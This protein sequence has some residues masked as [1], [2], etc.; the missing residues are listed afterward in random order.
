LTWKSKAK[1][2]CSLYLTESEVFSIQGN[3]TILLS[4]LKNGNAIIDS[5]ARKPI[6]TVK[7][8]INGSEQTHYFYINQIGFE[9]R[10]L[11][12][13]LSPTDIIDAWELLGSENSELND[14]LIN[15]L[16]TLTD[17]QQ[18][19]S[20]KL[21][22]DN[23]VNKSLLNE[24]ARHFYGL[25]K[26][27]EFLFD[28]N[29]YK[30]NNSLQAAHSNN[31]RYYLTCDNV[32]TLYSYI[33]Y[34]GKQYTNDTIMSTYYWLILNIIV[35]NFYQN[36]NLWKIVKNLNSENLNRSELRASV[37][38]ITLEVEVEIKRVEKILSVDKKKI[39]WVMKIL[40]TGY[41]VY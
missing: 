14:W 40:Q 1:T 27:E 34:L 23:S 2:D 6:L 15:I 12:F 39:K 38:K 8:A 11:E 30:K 17:Q 33:N 24:M 22:P 26:L 18:D 3:A 35:T 19:E 25:V 29:V 32:D 36:R 28:E 13:R 16:E 21:L 9:S 41:G 37:E 10:P 31:I 20:G 4:G 5:I 7:E